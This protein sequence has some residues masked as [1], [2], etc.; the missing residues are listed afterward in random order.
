VTVNG[1]NTPEVRPPDAPAPSP[2]APRPAGRPLATH[3]SEQEGHRV[4]RSECGPPLEC[5]VA[6]ADDT[7]WVQP[8]GEVDLVT[9][10]LVAE[11]LDDVRAAR[12]GHV[13]LD[14]R[15]ATFVDS[16]ALH[17][18]LTWQERARRQRFTFVL[19]VGPGP[20][21]RAIDA[22]GL[23]AVLTIVSPAP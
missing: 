6:F 13:V 11:R 19:A 14:L 2:R 9:V 22:A 10:R 5:R 20:V 1:A 18:A 3:R 21:R 7:A 23:G 8:I 4:D 15:E 12:A 17:L 16:T